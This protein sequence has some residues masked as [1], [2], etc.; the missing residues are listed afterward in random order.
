MQGG[1]QIVEKADLRSEKLKLLNSNNLVRTDEYKLGKLT[2]ATVMTV[3]SYMTIKEL[4][5][6]VSKINKKI[7]KWLIKP[8]LQKMFLV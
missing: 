8:G 4:I 7:R 3:F 6:K 2:Q 1:D 5:N